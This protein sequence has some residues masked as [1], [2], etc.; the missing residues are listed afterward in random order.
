[1]Y[2]VTFLKWIGIGMIRDRLFSAEIEPAR[3]RDG[4]R[5]ANFLIRVV[6]TSIETSNETLD[7]TLFFD[8]TDDPATKARNDAP[9]LQ[10]Q[11]PRREEG[12]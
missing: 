4:S 9:S 11:V 8:H 6:M 12:L 3:R 10:C 5:C 7:H 2:Q 1:M